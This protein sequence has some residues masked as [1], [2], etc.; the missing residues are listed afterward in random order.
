MDRLLVRIEVLVRLVIEFKFV[1][2]LAFVVSAIIIILLTAATISSTIITTI[3]LQIYYYC[4][5]SDCYC[6]GYY[7]EALIDWNRNQNVEIV[8]VR[9][10]RCIFQTIYLQK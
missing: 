5:F 10:Y 1:V 4:C 3:I 8:L 2:S 9:E 7:T 6:Y